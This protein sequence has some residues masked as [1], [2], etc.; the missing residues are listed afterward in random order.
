MYQPHKATTKAITDDTKMT[1]EIAR[2]M[3]PLRTPREVFQTANIFSIRLGP[4]PNF[5][6]AITRRNLTVRQFKAILT[7]LA[8]PYNSD[9]DPPVKRS[10]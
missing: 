2:R 4:I 6:V 9:D 8:I 3:F 5:W 1:E 7:A 10:R